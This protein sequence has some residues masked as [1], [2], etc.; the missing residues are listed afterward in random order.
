LQNFADVIQT[1]TP[2]NPGNSG[3]PL[4]SSNGKL[5]GINSFGQPDSPGLNYAVAFTSVKEFLDSKTSVLVSKKNSSKTKGGECEHTTN[6]DGWPLA[7]C[8]DD[9]NGINDR[10]V[11]DGREFRSYLDVYYDRNENSV[12][13]MMLRVVELEDGDAWII[14]F[15]SE[16][17]GSWTKTGVDY[18]KDG[19]VDEWLE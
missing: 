5:I 4:I 19:N 11:L 10:F 14:K 13:E 12:N 3:G 16:E 17:T 1:Q 6:S 9:N 8:D 2:I 18:D 15:D 7:I